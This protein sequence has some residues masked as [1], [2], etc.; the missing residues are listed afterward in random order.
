[1]KSVTGIVL[2]LGDAVVYVKSSKQKFSARSS[3]DS[4]LVAISDSLS[5]LLWT[6]EYMLSSHTN[7][8]PI[9]LYQDNKSTV[10]LA[11]KRRS[12]RTNVDV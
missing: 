11:N 10:C 7:V 9:V 6:R 4:E 2:M 3:T 12:T 1:M 8:G 5:H